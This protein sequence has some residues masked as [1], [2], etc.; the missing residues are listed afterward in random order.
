MPIAIE[1][2]G[3]SKLYKLYDSPNQRLKELATFNRVQAHRELW[4]LR[5]KR[6]TSALVGASSVE[7][8]DTNLDALGNLAFTDE[9]LARI[10]QHALEA[11]INL[12]ARATEG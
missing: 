6:V 1:L 7:Q 12:W 5:D 2:T 4:V 9:Q 8:L 10:D 3:V 11:G